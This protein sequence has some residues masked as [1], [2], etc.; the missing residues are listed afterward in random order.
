MSLDGMTNMDDLFREGMSDDMRDFI[1]AV[2]A[3]TPERSFRV[4]TARPEQMRAYLADATLWARLTAQMERVA[5]QRGWPATELH[6]QHALVLVAGLPLRN[7]WM[8]SA[9]VCA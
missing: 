3:L 9:E 8:E 7:V 6:P 2:L 4:T 5:Q 1:F